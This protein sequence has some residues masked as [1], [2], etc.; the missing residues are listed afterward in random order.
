MQEHFALLALDGMINAVMPYHLALAAFGIV[1]GIIVGALPGLSS[2]TA[3]ALLV[4]MT[5]TMEPSTGLILLGAIWTGAIYGGSN[6]AILLNIPG[7]PSSVATA[8]DGY[9]MTKNGQGERALFTGLLS[10][11]VGGLVGVLILLFAFAPLAVLS[12]K[13]GKA[14]FFWLCVFGLSTIAAMSSD[15]CAKG[16]LGG[17]IGL[18]LGTIGLD[19]VIGVPRFTY[20]FD[21]LIDGVQLVPALIGIFAFA[22]V[23][24][25]TQQRKAVIAEYKKTPNLFV[26]V[27]REL[28]QKCKINL[29]RSSLIGSFIGM[30]P[31]A[32]GPVASLISYSEAVRWDKNPARFGKGA[33]DGVVASEAANNAVI[34]GSLVPMMG[35]G[36]PGCA[37]AA[38]VMS[39][40]LVHGIIPGSKLLTESAP[41]AY[42][43]IMS[44]V[45]ANVLMLIIGFWMLRLSANLLRVPVRW[46]VPM[47]IILAAIGSY[48]LRNS[49]VD[50]Y[51]MVA[52]GIGSFFLG[53][54]GVEAGPISLGLVL[55]PIVED[56]LNISLTM[57]RAKGSYLE[58]FL[59]RPLCLLF[60]A[61]TILSL[62]APALQRRKMLRAAE[63]GN[64]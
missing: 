34:G 33:V 58:V 55:G 4:P 13:F 41:I 26:S 57:V 15:N 38:V 43:F 21:S 1:I 35:L 61:L 8:F 5:F 6:A 62:A 3:C 20:G 46:I 32:G 48:S 63:R 29:A 7:T 37:T 24:E 47:V 36:I 40:L 2:T 25:L 54:V 27:V 50:V 52:C 39:G 30:L 23:L 28:F 22:Q 9:P 16:L 53:K 31:G 49:M 11:V 44:L 56:A 45:V 19:P 59:F 42:T 18:M 17:C 51:V 64:S 60:I 14:E 10:S 12:V